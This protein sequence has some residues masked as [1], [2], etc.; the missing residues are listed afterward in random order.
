MRWFVGDLHIHTALSPCAEDEM[1][2]PSIVGR[3]L[4]AGLDIIAITDH[5]TAG[6]AE[7]VIEAARGTSLKVLP[8]MEVQ[9]R[10][11]VHLLCLFP[12]V[13]ATLAWQEEVYR[14]LPPRDNPEALFG[15]QRLLDARGREKGREKR[16]LLNSADL[17]VRQ[18]TERVPAL[19]G[20]VIPA[21]VDRR[22][23]S[24]L[25]T[26]GI[27]PP[28]LPV[29]ALEVSRKSNM[30][31]VRR[32]LPPGLEYSWITSSDAHNLKDIGRSVTCF[33]LREAT[34]GEILLAL[35]G[36]EGRKVV[37]AQERP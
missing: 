8:G 37:M 2:P 18:V 16:F 22:A 13:R 11:E 5:N 12:E 28:D 15:A 31:K 29:A 25:G 3:A 36:Q 9:T 24:L 30:E 7:A 33:Y 6:N 35:K 23:Y 10:E 26:L 1:S 4:E 19:G 34:L 20:L 17:G 14:H 32:S 27:V 21:H